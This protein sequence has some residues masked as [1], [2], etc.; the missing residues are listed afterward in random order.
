MVLASPLLLIGYIHHGYISYTWPNTATIVLF[1]RISPFSGHPVVRQSSTQ[2]DTGWRLRFQHVGHTQ[3]AAIGWDTAVELWKTTTWL[4]HPAG[5]LQY[6]PQ[7]TRMANEL[8]FLTFDIPFQYSP[9]WESLILI[10]DSWFIRIAA[11][12]A[13]AAVILV[14]LV[15]GHQKPVA[16]L[17][18]GCYWN[19]KL[20]SRN[21]GRTVCSWYCTISADNVPRNIN[22]TTKS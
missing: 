19:T 17:F 14:V 18:S 15:I 6:E 5:L 9:I 11:G 8:C 7:V 1:L 13:L 10:N 3:S 2:R 20:A 16:E 12:V 22:S 21:I 4:F